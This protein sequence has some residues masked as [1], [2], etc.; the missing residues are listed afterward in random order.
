[1]MRFIEKLREL[2]AGKPVGFK[3]CVG[4]P[5]EFMSLVKAMLETGTTPDFIV[6]D[7]SEG[8]TGAAPLEFVDHVGMPLR[9]GLSFVHNTLV[10]AGIRDRV[11]IGASGKIITGFDMVRAIALGA[12]FCNA[13]RGFMFAVGCIQAQA[14]HTGKCPV[15]VTSQDPSRQRAIVVADKSVRVANFHAATIEAMADLIA[16]AGLDTPSRLG[17]RHIYRRVSQQEYI[18]YADLYPCLQPGELLAGCSNQR[19]A[20]PWRTALAESFHSSAAAE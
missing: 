1:M 17:P 9:D 8:G 18:T 11:R 10:G 4:H 6:V 20:E 13:A 19:Y 16:A 3:L 7:G 5:R 14:C 12:D 15:G 2:S